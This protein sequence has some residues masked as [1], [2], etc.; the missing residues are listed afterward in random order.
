LSSTIF[1]VLSTFAAVAPAGA[2][3]VPFVNLV[4]TKITANFI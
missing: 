2:K 1:I 4:L 3:P